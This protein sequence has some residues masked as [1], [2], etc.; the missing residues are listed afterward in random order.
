VLGA[1][2]Q[3]GF[4]LIPK[5]VQR[6]IEVAALTRG[7]APTAVSPC[8]GLAWR[9]Y[10]PQALAVSLSGASRFDAA[11]CLAPLPALLPLLCDLARLGVRRLVA[12]GTT[13]RF[14]KSASADSNE[15]RHMQEFVAAE[16]E[17][18]GRCGALGIEWTLL[19]PTLVYGCGRDG[20]IAFIAR[21][22]RRFGFFPLCEGGRGLRQPV[23]A[24]DL[25]QAC[26]D[27][28][29]S[30]HTCAKAYNLSGGSRLTFRQMVEAVF[31]Q[32]GRP[33]LTPRVPTGLLRAAIAAARRLPRLGGLSTEMAARMGEDM[34]F[35][36]Q[37]AAL[38][39]GFCPRPFSLDD[40]SVGGGAR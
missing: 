28:L 19:R 30:P 10:S 16:A 22:I 39:F 25:A 15:Q 14:Y 35:D 12:F 29:D 5:L 26:A 3:V 9:T 20:N 23:H 32:L 4:F 8:P 31:R 6:G 37:D 18:P 36:H 21:F 2:S 40:L 17:L 34:C 24:A 11:V 38:D 27:V 13:S 1:T 33:V 7:T